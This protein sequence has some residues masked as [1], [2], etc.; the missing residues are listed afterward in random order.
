MRKDKEFM[1]DK[2]KYMQWQQYICGD[3]AMMSIF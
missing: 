2:M 1:K 3:L